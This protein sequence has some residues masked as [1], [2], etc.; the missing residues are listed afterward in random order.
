MWSLVEK[1]S[2]NVARTRLVMFSYRLLNSL[3]YIPA[4]DSY[5]RCSSSFWCPYR[6]RGI[7]RYSGCSPGLRGIFLCRHHIIMFSVVYRTQQS[8]SGSLL[9]SSSPW[10]VSQIHFQIHKQSFSGTTSSTSANR[11]RALKQRREVRMYFFFRAGELQGL[12]LL[13][14][15]RDGNHG[16]AGAL[17][18]VHL[19]L[20]KAIPLIRT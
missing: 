19:P 17:S 14:S 16:H 11:T 1:E 3:I 20:S 4:A 12:H 7:G 15:I 2:L 18:I 6:H 5:T 10:N 13:K 8:S 9:A